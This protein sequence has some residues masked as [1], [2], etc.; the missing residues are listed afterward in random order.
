MVF[1][2]R[3]SRFWYVFLRCFFLRGSIFVLCASSKKCEQSR[4]VWR[5]VPGATGPITQPLLCVE[6]HRQV[7]SGI[8]VGICPKT[9]DE[10]DERIQ[11]VTM[12]AWIIFLDSSLEHLTDQTTQMCCVK[13]TDLSF[14]AQV[15]VAWQWRIFGRKLTWFPEKHVIL[16][17][18]VAKGMLEWCTLFRSS[19]MLIRHDLH[20]CHLLLVV[21]IKETLPIVD[22][23]HA[24]GLFR[25]GLQPNVYLQSLKLT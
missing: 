20:V 12:S 5:E 3:Q 21:E 24:I 8:H 13:V 10:S 22:D 25:M 19:I 1:F 11:H 23:Q 14:P 15:W 6:H 4:M 2:L 17:V 7:I 9:G 16:R 18:C